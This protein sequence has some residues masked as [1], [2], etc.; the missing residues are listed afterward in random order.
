MKSQENPI[1]GLATKEVYGQ[2][3]A[4]LT[5]RRRNKDGTLLIG[6]AVD[7]LSVVLNKTVE[8]T[9]QLLSELNEY[10]L[11]LGLSVATYQSNQKEW[12]AIKSL[13]AA[14]I[15]LHEDELTVLGTVIMLIEQSKE[16]KVET[17]KIVDYLAKREYF[18]EYK[19]K[20]I[21][22]TLQENGY[23][24]KSTAGGITYGSRTLI[25]INDESRRFISQ[26]ASELLF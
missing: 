13:Y 14:P 1:A 10:L 6:Y 18:N 11:G 12:A 2:V 9:N 3:L 17:Q 19:I 26:Q 5:N 15:E 23:L 20:K 16:P 7:E 8:D 22:K 24:K 25:E 21:V 4:I